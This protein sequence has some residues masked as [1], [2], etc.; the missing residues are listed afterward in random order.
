MAPKLSVILF[1]HWMLSSLVKQNS[2]HLGLTIV[3][4]VDLPNISRELGTLVTSCVPSM[5]L[6]ATITVLVSV[7]EMSMLNS[8]GLVL[9]MYN[10][11]VCNLC[12]TWP[13]LYTCKFRLNY[14]V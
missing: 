3:M 7:F 2:I 12:F 13:T 11:L 5:T 8:P 4:C 6:T 10:P 14:Q 9:A 1:W